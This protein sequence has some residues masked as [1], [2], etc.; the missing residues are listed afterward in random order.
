MSDEAVVEKK[1]YD[2]GELGL[3]LKSKGLELAEE[4]AHLVAQSFFEWLDES[5]KLSQNPYDDM[6]LIILPKVKE[7]I[8]SQIEKI[9]GKPQE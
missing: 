1:A 7:F 8:D 3:K 2:L 4:S 5:A 9:D 6:V